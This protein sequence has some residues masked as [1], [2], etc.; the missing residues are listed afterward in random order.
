MSVEGSLIGQAQHSG[1]AVLSSNLDRWTQRKQQ[2]QC[3]SSLWDHSLLACFR[4]PASPPT[5]LSFPQSSM[6]YGF[7]FPKILSSII[8][9]SNESFPGKIS[10]MASI[11]RSGRVPFSWGSTVPVTKVTHKKPA[12]QAQWGSS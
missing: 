4:L 12:S 10:K 1:K 9:F 7:N 3:F 6:V 5:F 8:F 2:I 11:F